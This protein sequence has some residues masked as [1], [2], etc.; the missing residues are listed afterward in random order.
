[1]LKQQSPIDILAGLILLGCLVWLILENLHR[2][3]ETSTENQNQDNQEPNSKDN[4]V[5]SKPNEINPESTLPIEV[6]SSTQGTEEQTDEQS[7]RSDKVKVEIKDSVELRALDDYP[8]EIRRFQIPKQGLTEAECEDKSALSSTEGRLR[9]AVADGATESLFSDIWA[10]LIVNSYVDKGAEIFNIGSL[11]SL[12]Q[13]FLHTA[14]KL[15]LQMPETRHWFMYEKLERGSHVTFVAAEFYNPETMEVLAVGD[16][17]I[18]WRNEENGNVEMLP[19]LSAED[20]GVFPASICSLQKTWQN[21]ESKI[22]KKEVH[23]HNGF[24]VILCTD[25]LACWLVKALQ[26]DPFVWE[27]LFQLSDSISFTNFIDS[28][29]SQKEIRNDDVTLV[30]I[31][32]IPIN[33]RL[34]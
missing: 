14:S 23:L 33:V 28:L 26:Q 29:R 21:L 31:H 7:S 30:L 13:A 15:I 10:E 27:K 34:P 2:D 11:Q 22:V 4:P 25:A 5:V 19:E 24:Q 17:C 16:S 9:V 3:K 8:V 12:S 18:F 6:D 1:M 20:F 32:A